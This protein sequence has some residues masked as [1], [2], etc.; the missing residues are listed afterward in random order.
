MQNFIQNIRS[1]V[2]IKFFTVNNMQN[3]HL[4]HK[5]TR[6]SFSERRDAH[7]DT[8]NMWDMYCH[9]RDKIMERIEISAFFLIFFVFA[10][11]KILHFD[12]N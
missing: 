11:V 10:G 12:K 2:K 4:S 5:Q 9:F 3:S 1:G 7:N 8:K 6:R